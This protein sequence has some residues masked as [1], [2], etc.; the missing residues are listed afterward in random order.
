MSVRYKEAGDHMKRLMVQ[1]NLI[2]RH[3]EALKYWHMWLV[4]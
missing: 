4:G 3:G 1:V 2:T